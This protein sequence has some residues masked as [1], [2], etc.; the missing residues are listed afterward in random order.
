MDYSFDGQFFYPFVAPLHLYDISSQ[1]IRSTV[2]NQN[3]AAD[4]VPEEKGPINSKKKNGPNMYDIIARIE[5]VEGFQSY[6]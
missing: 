5:R 6:Q 3:T 4:L 2:L 1:G